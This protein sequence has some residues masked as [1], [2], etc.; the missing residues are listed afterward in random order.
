MHLRLVGMTLVAAA[1]GVACSNSSDSVGASPADA[2]TACSD[3]IVN[4][5]NNNQGVTCP[6][7]G[8]GNP[9]PYDQAIGTTCSALN[10]NTGF[11]TYGQCFDYLV[12]E[13]SKDGTD[14]NASKCFYDVHTHALVGIVYGDGMMDQCGGA[15]T[16]VQAGQVEPKC[17]VD[18]GPGSS[19]LYESCAPVPE[20]GEG[21][22][23][24]LGG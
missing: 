3:T 17:A 2:G 4:V 1:L 8:N 19:G 7:D 20:G 21:G 11:V 15:A 5:F 16:T 9:L 22:A 24:P 6:L 18:N 10:M 12:W 14:A 23:T 13:S